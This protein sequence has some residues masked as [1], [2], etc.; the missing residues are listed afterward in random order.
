M[1]TCNFE[2]LIWKYAAINKKKLFIYLKSYW[3]NYNFLSFLTLYNA[4]LNR[5]V[6][7]HEFS[8]N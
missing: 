1:E 7:I 3:S 2:N 4:D 8:K 6:K 5:K